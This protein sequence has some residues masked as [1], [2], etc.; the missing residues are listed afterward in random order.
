MIRGAKKRDAEKCLEKLQQE[1]NFDETQDQVPLL[2][3][4]EIS[5]TNLQ[6]IG[7]TKEKQ[8]QSKRRLSTGTE[9]ISSISD[10][11]FPS[12]CNEGIAA[13]I[14]N[15]ELDELQRHKI[16]G[17][18]CFSA[19][20]EMCKRKEKEN[21]NEIF[22]FRCQ[23]ARLLADG[24]VMLQDFGTLTWEGKTKPQIIPQEERDKP[25]KLKHLFFKT[26]SVS[27]RKGSNVVEME[28]GEGKL[29][30]KHLAASLNTTQQRM[31]D[32]LTGKSSG[33]LNPKDKVD[34]QFL[35]DTLT[36]INRLCIENDVGQNKETCIRILKDLMHTYYRGEERCENWYYYL[37]NKCEFLYCVPRLQTLARLN[38]ENDI[39]NFVAFAMLMEYFKVNGTTVTEKKNAYA[40]FPARF[41]SNQDQTTIILSDDVRKSSKV[42]IAKDLL[43]EMNSKGIN[44]KSLNLVG[45]MPH[46]LR[47]K[48]L[49][50][51]TLEGKVTDVVF[52]AKGNMKDSNAEPH[53]RKESSFI[54]KSFLD[55]ATTEVNSNTDDADDAEG[56]DLDE[57]EVSEFLS[58]ITCDKDI[59]NEKDDVFGSF[60]MKEVVKDFEAVEEAERRKE[61]K[62]MAN[63]EEM[64]KQADLYE[65]VRIMDLEYPDSVSLSGCKFKFVLAPTGILEQLLMEIIY[66][67]ED[68]VMQHLLDSANQAKK[69]VQK[70]TFQPTSTTA[71]AAG[72]KYANANVL[73]EDEDRYFNKV[74]LIDG[75]KPQI[76][77]ILRYQNHEDFQDGGKYSDFEF[78]KLPAKCSGCLQPNDL[79][80]GFKII[81][82]PLQQTKK[83]KTVGKADMYADLQKKLIEF[84]MEFSALSSEKTSLITTFLRVAGA[85]CNEAFSAFKVQAGYKQAIIY[86]YN[87]EQILRKCKNKSLDYNLIMK[88][89][90]SNRKMFLEEIH[91][92][93]LLSDKTM[94]EVGIPALNSVAHSKPDLRKLANILDK[95]PISTIDIEKELYSEEDLAFINKFD[96]DLY[97]RNLLAYILKR[98]HIQKKYVDETL[99][100]T[101]IT[102]LQ[103]FMCDCLGLI[104]QR[105][106][107]LNHKE[108]QNHDTRVTEL[109]EEEKRIKKITEDQLREAKANKEKYKKELE[110]ICK[111][112]WNSIYRCTLCSQI[113]DIAPED[114]KLSESDQRTIN[115]VPSQDDEPTSLEKLLN[116]QDYK[117]DGDIVNPLYHIFFHVSDTWATKP[118]FYCAL[119]NGGTL[120]VD[121]LFK[122]H[123]KGCY[124]CNHTLAYQY[125][126][127][128]SSFLRLRKQA[129]AKLLNQHS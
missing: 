39:R 107:R 45:H 31:S 110:K 104:R 50:V 60:E 54:L 100:E 43:K 2:S 47:L 11:S 112:K 93:G 57:E 4:A 109:R 56:E 49:V 70:C 124:K 81:K 92:T 127:D 73:T 35:V 10:I 119:C 97:V 126:H 102:D 58:S 94:K 117:A 66:M 86:N 9:S 44:L 21:P 90:E 115:Q 27:K 36:R 87:L 111:D 101:K 51:T 63:R 95:K 46:Y 42:A 59:V 75:D 33:G 24:W 7:G 37:I 84:I 55:N 114:Q 116:S 14:F 3:S 67:S 118:S 79:M 68:G 12:T 30:Q 13:D 105:A 85:K 28:K 77:M 103:E 80:E 120:Y 123:K 121:Y 1:S 34:R 17:R 72:T 88:I 18:F 128:L 15:N 106:C 69:Q 113:Y 53:F 8:R 38:A 22:Q 6:V 99:I 48:T 83:Q 19:L 20:Q 65:K 64:L 125:C 82:R 76:D 26:L 62:I 41:M 78:G 89:V 71:K 91:K 16:D 40:H 96:V 25:V 98:K 5:T 23:I 52:I 122:S 29:Y 108:L 74:H 32:Y 61:K 129:L